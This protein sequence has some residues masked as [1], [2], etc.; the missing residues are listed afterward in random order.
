MIS[1]F[2]F[3][4][5]VSAHFFVSEKCLCRKV[6]NGT[7]TLSNVVPARSTCFHLGIQRALTTSVAGGSVQAVADGSLNQPDLVMAAT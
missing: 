6:E 5:I 1:V 3:G 4:K 2:F 7:R